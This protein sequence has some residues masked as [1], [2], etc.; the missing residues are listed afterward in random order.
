M[1]ESALSRG[2]ARANA[3]RVLI[4]SADIGEGHDLPARLLLEGI[5]ERRPDAVVAI[6]DSLK[7]A[8]RVVYKLVR[9]G[10]E[11]TLESFP[12]G[13]DAQYFLITRMPTRL[14]TSW[15]A[16]R[17]AHRGLARVIA[18]F[19]PDVIVSTYPGANEVLG[20]M[21]RAGEL[22]VPLVS[23]ITDLAALRFWAHPEFDLHL[24][25]HAESEPEVR[26]M[27]G[28]RTRIAHVS[29]LTDPQF[30]E[31][32]A[33]ADARR[34]LGLPTEGPVVVISGGGWG[35]GDLEG[36]VRVCL[37]AAPDLTAVALCGRNDPLRERIE[38]D[39]ASEGSRVRAVGFT[40]RMGDYLA[41][42]D[43]LV[44][45]TAGLTVLEAQIRGARVISYGW[46]VGHIRANNRAYREFGLAD[47]ASTPAA[48]AAA[49]ESALASPR[50]PDPSLAA[51][52]AAADVTLELVDGSSPSS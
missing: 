30:L 18:D 39:F 48:L 4:F 34:D 40:T 42:A 22:D 10:V 33:T 2:P 8:G 14:F 11:G 12:R 52:P 3:P 21:R 37:D 17:M 9:E 47:V 26:A 5:A 13:Y 23:A 46:G 19:C 27:A 41:A 1:T 7:A 24:I 51:L 44:H 6:A 49:L 32:V 20:R 31:P 36:A 45:S 28:P 16:W 29:G 15:L 35:V 50:D 38:R 43:V 25:I